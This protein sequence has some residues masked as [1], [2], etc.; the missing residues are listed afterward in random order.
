MACPLFLPTSSLGELSAIAPP[1]GD[2]LAGNCAADPSAVIETDILRR[3]C[4]FGYAR[5]HCERAAQADADAARFMIQGERDAVV[6]VAWALEKDHHPVAV[7]VIEV[8]DLAEA[9]P[10][11]DALLAQARSCARTYRRQAH[12]RAVNPGRM[13]TPEH[14]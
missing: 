6:Q 10:S 14:P 13:P 8:G 5:D 9:E 1:L 7:G 4:N 12:A 3:C 2:L 11:G